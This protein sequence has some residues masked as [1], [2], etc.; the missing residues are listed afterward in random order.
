MHLG[1]VF[2]ALAWVGAPYVLGDDPEYPGAPGDC[3]GFV[4]AHA[5]WSGA[6]EV[7]GDKT[8][9]TIF[10]GSR[11]VTELQPGDLVFVVSNGRAVHVGVIIL[12]GPQQVQ[13]AHASTSRRCVVVDTVQVSP[14]GRPLSSGWNAA[15]APAWWPPGADRRRHALDLV[16]EVV[17]IQNAGGAI[18]WL[19]SQRVS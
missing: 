17:A 14:S 13:V 7:G 6:P 18:E 5:R 4:L 3:S 1:I 10:R 16:P 12:V 2:V 8:A 15:G 9:D 11:P 19:R